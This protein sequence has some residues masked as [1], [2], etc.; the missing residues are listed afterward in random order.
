MEIMF[1]LSLHGPQLAQTTAAD[2]SER[3]LAG[4]SWFAV[5]TEGLLEPH[6]DSLIAVCRLA[7]AFKGYDLE[8]SLTFASAPLSTR[9]LGQAHSEDVVVPSR[10]R[11]LARACRARSAQ[12]RLGVGEL[13]KRPRIPQARRLYERTA[14]R[15]GEIKTKIGHSSA[16][17]MRTLA[18]RRGVCRSCWPITRRTVSRHPW[19]EAVRNG[20]RTGGGGMQR[21]ATAVKRTQRAEAALSAPRRMSAKVRVGARGRRYT[22]RA[23]R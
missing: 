9:L 6:G 11:G 5:H 10:V 7:L 12:Q 8:P 20:G 2:R 3:L 18:V 4:G 14:Q 17:G 16:W 1:V 19:I 23:R 22:A 15:A 13:H 21:G